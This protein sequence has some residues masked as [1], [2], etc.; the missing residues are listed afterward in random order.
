MMQNMPNRS[1]LMTGQSGPQN[2][3]VQSQM[4]NNPP[5]TYRPNPPYTHN[6][7]N[8][9]YCPLPTPEDAKKQ[10]AESLVSEY[11]RLHNRKNEIEARMKEL[12]FRP[13]Q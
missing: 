11:N 9:N 6:Q 1:M 3:N 4:H 7:Q 10:E 2:P 8:L 5:P 12:G 13:Q